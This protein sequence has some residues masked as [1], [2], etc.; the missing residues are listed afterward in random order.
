LEAEFSSLNFSQV[1]WLNDFKDPIKI[2]NLSPSSE[3]LL[4]F[5]DENLK[6]LSPPLY[7]GPRSIN[8]IRDDFPILQNKM[9]GLKPLIWFD[10]A[11]TTQKPRPVIE[12]LVRY[13]ETENSNVHRGAHSLASVA[14]DA[15]EGARNKVASFIGAPQA[16]NIVFTRGTTEAINL[17]AH[18]FVKPR[19]SNGD[20]ILLT[21]LE[22]HANIVPWQIIAQQTGALIRVA[23]TDESGQLIYHRF[24]ELI[25]PNTKFASFSHVSNALGT[26]VDITS[27]ISVC[28]SLGVPTLV[29]AAQSVAHIPINAALLGCD[30]LVFSGHKIYG[31][32]G[33]GALY[34]TIEALNQTLPWQGGGHMI[35]DV[36][37]ER[38]IYQDPPV[39]FEA[40]TPNIAGAVGLGAA[41]DYLSSLGLS[42]VAQYEESLLRYASSRLR[43]IDGLKIIGDSENKVSVI[44]FILDGF[45]PA[46]VGSFLSKQGVAVR[47]GH[48]CAQPIL[49]RFGLE[50]TVRPSLALY[51]TMEEIDR[52]VES[53]ETL[54]KQRF[55]QSLA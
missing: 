21:E 15:Y 26:V 46:E 5:K 33:I 40:G 39:R 31:P 38:T 8:D 25:G 45:T 17:V 11:A 12:R 51:N 44:S 29:D 7:P 34:G 22:H 1:S 37:F 14:T 50:A 18:G 10:N 24:I 27:L 9:E 2:A 6:P 16:S 36:T 3:S 41:L 19:L 28:R 48:H 47:A 13:Y 52:L 35:S 30:F 49:R 32:T 55:K 42:S 4:P 53:L 20:E 23:P 43:S 54:L